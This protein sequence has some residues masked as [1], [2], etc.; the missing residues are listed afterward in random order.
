VLG[1]LDRLRLLG[2][3]AAQQ[4][5]V[6]PAPEKV[7]EANTLLS[8]L[9]FESGGLAAAHAVH[10]GLTALAD[11]GLGEAGKE[12]LL[13][14]AKAATVPGETIHNMPFAVTSEMVV[15]AMVAA[16]SYSRAYRQE[17]GQQAAAVPN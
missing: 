10:N 4:H 14:V 12:K 5:V 13:T 2:R 6:T 3:Q 11:L 7:V 9:G 16:D 8:G 15:D 1:H 17:S